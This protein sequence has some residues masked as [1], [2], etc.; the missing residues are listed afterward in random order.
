VKSKRH[1]T[2][3]ALS[4]AFIAGCQRSFFKYM[5]NDLQSMDGTIT[6]KPDLLAETNRDLSVG[7]GWKEYVAN[8]FEK[9]G[10]EQTF[11]IGTAR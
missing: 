8:C 10:R 2:E 7:F 5:A 11:G 3:L 4:S 6:I 1:Q 9:I